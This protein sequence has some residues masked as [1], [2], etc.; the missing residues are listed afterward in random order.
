MTDSGWARLEALFHEALERPDAERGDWVRRHCPDDSELAERVLELLECADDEDESTIRSVLGHAAR[1]VSSHSLEPAPIRLGPYRITGCLG[2]GGM[3]TVYRAERDDR[4]Y[5]Q[6]VAIKLLRGFPGTVALERLR[7]ERQILADLQHPH[8]ARLLDGGA[9]GDGQPY[10]VME[11]IEGSPLVQWCRDTNPSRDRR[12]RLMMHIC[13]AVHHA[14]RHLVIH[15][16]LKPGN[17]LVTESGS[18]RVLDFGIATNAS[19]ADGE[20]DSDSETA[21]PRF[22]TPGFASPEQ[23]AGRPVST[24]TDIYSLGRLLLAVLLSTEK[25]DDVADGRRRLP[26]DLAAIVDRATR[27]EPEERYASVEGLRSDLSRY[28]D[29]L[30]VQAVGDR[31]LYRA[32]KFLWRN[33][34]ATGVAAV[35]IFLILSLGWRWMVE[36][37][38]ARTA[39][40]RA[41]AEA[42]NAE[43]VLAF[44]LDAIGAAEP[45]NAGS[46]PVSVREVVDRAR[47][48]VMAN[49][50]IDESTRARMCLA[51][52]EVYL[53]LED[54][55]AAEELLGPAAATGD[56]PTRVRANS[57]IGY[58][59]I[60]Q[61]RHDSA[62]E[63]LARAERLVEDHPHLPSRLLLELRN[64]RALW[65]LD[66]DRPEDARD[67]FA[68]IS[69]AYFSRGDRETAA[70]MLHN[71]GLAESTLGQ[72]ET[73]VSNFEQSLSLK[74]ETVGA[75]HLSVATTLQAL[76]RAESRLGRYDPAREH[77]E[78]AVQL[79]RQIFGD[80]HPGLHGDYNELG[81]MLHDRG[82][83][84]RAIEHYQRAQALLER[85]GVSTAQAA[86]YINNRAHAYADRGEI[87]RA[88]PLFEQSLT[89]RRAHFGDDHLSVARARHNL[90]RALILS[91]RGEEAEELIEKALEVRRNV[92]GDDHPEAVYTESLWALR[93]FH[94]G[95]YERSRDG[96]RRAIDQMAEGLPPSNWWMLNLRGWLSRSLLAMGEHEAALALID[97]I[98]GDYRRALG[99]GHPHAMALELERA[100]VEFESGREDTARRRL[101]QVRGPIE[102]HMV[103][104]SP[105]RLLLARLVDHA[106]D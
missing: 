101:A 47:E 72:L 59:R 98:V 95:D 46:E 80:D 21:A 69:Q 93:A 49:R 75:R 73:A 52:G 105:P 82:D 43:S 55:D 61:Q 58:G 85:E 64:H 41:V 88:L 57:L 94:R 35:A 25:P 91:G 40:F 65:W 66:N 67:A 53:R 6:K 7:R 96:F 84:G 1:E 16:D 11:Y 86:V 76:A 54:W 33:R 20:A 45:G 97:E 31:F 9:T 48:G 22:C 74:E 27:E 68:E 32:R 39:E 81:S 104:G 83:F 2:Q 4:N 8:I 13:D 28:L 14:H 79:R 100:A 60:L 37:D 23:L 36:F 89:L 17:I 87:E 42:R 12:I 34:E 70:R 24:A 78:R 15:R 30:P 38:R 103:P 102:D 77:L 106:A 90:A 18:P 3:G 56:P 10:L 71:L 63:A 19:E 44:V 50:L 51:L 29:R 26:E 99:P 5:S 92:L 62:H